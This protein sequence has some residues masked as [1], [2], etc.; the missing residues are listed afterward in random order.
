VEIRDSRSGRPGPGE[1]ASY[2]QSD[3]DAVAGDDAVAALLR[4]RSET[5]ALF[6][7]FGETGGNVTYAPGKWTIKQV[8]GHLADDERIFAYRALCIARGDSR[9]LPGFDEN[10]YARA[11]RSDRLSLVDLLADYEAVRD[12][13]VT[14]FRGLDREAWLR[15]GIVNGYSA[16]PRGLAFHIAGHELHHLRIVR[17]RYLPLAGL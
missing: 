17:E 1:F 8:L 5:L 7:L 14:L 16:S 2:A 12:A 9:P 3:I 4:Q 13:S 10:V 11:A 6:E 15:T